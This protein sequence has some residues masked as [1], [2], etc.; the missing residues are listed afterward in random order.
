MSPSTLTQSVVSKPPKRKDVF[1]EMFSTCP[2]CGMRF[3]RR[4]NMKRHSNSRHE[5]MKCIPHP[6]EKCYDY[7]PPPPPMKETRYDY[8]P[9]PPPK[10]T[11][12]DY[13]PPPP[14]ETR[15]DYTP[16][17]KE[18]CCDYTPPPPP[19]KETGYDYTPP[20]HPPP[21]SPE[22]SL[23]Q[24]ETETE[25]PYFIYSTGNPWAHPFTSV[26]SEP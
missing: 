9:P 11:R 17:P 6:K 14:K 5:N 24:H 23:L 22:L 26:I 8:T 21:R 19:P 2:E 15:Y 20:L 1:Y 3:T 18:T 16:P 10:E 4:D 25:E 13:T 7:T 12:Y